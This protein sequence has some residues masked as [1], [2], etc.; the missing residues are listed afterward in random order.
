M[1]LWEAVSAFRQF[2]QALAEVFGSERWRATHG[3]SFLRFD[4]F[5]RTQ[6]RRALDSYLPVELTREIA[7]RCTGL[8]FSFSAE[9][10]YVR[11]A[12]SGL[13]AERDAITMSALDVHDRF[14]GS[15]IE[16]V[17]EYGSASVTD[18]AASPKSARLR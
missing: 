6:D 11:A 9:S 1:K 4:E 14:G 7:A 17:I 3:Q 16:E 18:S 12:T 15:V 13:A 10:G 8:Q 2:N 5:V